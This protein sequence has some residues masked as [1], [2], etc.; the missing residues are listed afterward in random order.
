MYNS[1]GFSFWKYIFLCNAKS[2]VS[3][4]F[5]KNGGLS[6]FSFKNWFQFI[7]QKLL[8]FCCQ[9]EKLN[10]N[11]MKK[12]KNRKYAWEQGS[13]SISKYVS[14][15]CD[16]IKILNIL[17]AYTIMQNFGKKTK[18][19]AWDFMSH[20]LLLKLSDFKKVIAVYIFCFC[21]I[22]FSISYESFIMLNSCLICLCLGFLGDLFLC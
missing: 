8:W 1:L 18:Y 20:Y 10:D 19:V 16:W 11:C 12:R 4:G 6:S 5:I 9:F 17:L 7:N 13:L 2:R 15:L 21:T 14:I 3:G 22:F